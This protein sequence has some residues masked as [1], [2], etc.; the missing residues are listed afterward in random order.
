MAQN[1]AP[2]DAPTS[3]WDFSH[4]VQEG[5]RFKVDDSEH[6]DIVSVRDDGSVRA[7][8][9]EFDD[10]E[11]WSQQGVTNSLANGDMVRVSDGKSHELATF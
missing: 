2:E 4:C 8:C 1:T 10:A 5:D 7:V 9:V 11:T 6:W 3:N